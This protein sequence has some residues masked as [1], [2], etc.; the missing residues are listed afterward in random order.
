MTNIQS[1]CVSVAG[2]IIMKIWVVFLYVEYLLGDHSRD[3]S[4]EG[5]GWNPR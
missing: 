1:L 5:L 4:P 2:M 3:S